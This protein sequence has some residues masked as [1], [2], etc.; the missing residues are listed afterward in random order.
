MQFASPSIQTIYMCVSN[1]FLIF[2]N[3][4]FW[5]LRVVNGGLDGADSLLAPLEGD[6]IL[7]ILSY[8]QFLHNS[9]RL[10]L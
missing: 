8:P 3:N 6:K 9:V 4:S 1:A 10:T 2:L 7:S 5:T